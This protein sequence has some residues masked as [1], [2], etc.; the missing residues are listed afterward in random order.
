MAKTQ[1]K[2]THSILSFEQKQPSLAY[3]VQELIQNQTIPQK[4]I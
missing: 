1:L 2:R 4:K 3:S